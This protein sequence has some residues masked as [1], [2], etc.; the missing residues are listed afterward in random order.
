MRTSVVTAVIPPGPPAPPA[1]GRTAR[2][3]VTATFGYVQLGLSL[4]VGIFLV[5]FV[6]AQVGARTYGFW[7]ASGEVLAY[8]AMAELGVFGVLPWMIAEAD[9]RR[10][11][12]SI[13]RLMSTAF[14]AGLCASAVYVA[15]ALTLWQL[16]PVLFNLDAAD[17][18]VI[19][20]PLVV[21]AATTAIVLPLRVAGATLVGL[22]DVRFSGILS[23]AAWALNVAATVA[24]LAS[25]RGLYALA[26]G[27]SLPSI[28]TV[29]AGVVRLRCIAPDLVRGW[30]APSFTDIVDL[31]KQGL[32]AWLS[33][34]GWRLSAASD[35]VV[36]AA[37][38][39]PL[40]IT[41]LAMT[42]KLGQM[43]TSMAWVPGDSGLV[44][45][46]QLSGEGDRAR[47]RAAVAALWRVY[48]GLASAAACVVLA[49]NGAFVGG[50]VGGHLFGGF[51]VNAVLAAAVIAATAG[52]AAA[53]ITSALGRR[54]HVGVATI[55]AGAVQVALAFMLARRFG[56]AGVPIAALAG[57]S[58][59]LLPSLL[60]AMMAQTGMRPSM[61][62]TQ[63]VRP[64]ALRSIPMLAAAAAAG[65]ML[66]AMP[67]AFAIP[68]GALTGL[69]Y[70][71]VARPL[72][73]DY[74]PLAA[75]IRSRLALLR[76][77]RLVPTPAERTSAP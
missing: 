13:R 23:T 65:L 44:G 40:A 10:D 30:S 54:L 52:H 47:L 35:A 16:A 74:P 26:V 43:L 6:L 46:A 67:L 72:L 29:V 58:L 39:N 4:I 21:L 63:I 51:R 2:A 76:L 24:L 45:L 14:T 9:G 1:T 37:V 8:A 59:V 66:P 32:G 25:G 56:V 28:V 73:L 19:D 27:A 38:G 5:P 71:W 50:W 75:L 64:W 12:E 41:V 34:W 36:L 68:L 17:R 62:W 3:S 69:L 11:R 22:Q 49:V 55:G 48:L 7:L 61:L 57:Q 70:L 18:R 60:P 33:A 20:G 77:E 31:W 42:A 53:T 15:A